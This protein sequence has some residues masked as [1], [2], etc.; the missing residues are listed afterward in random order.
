M[1]FFWV[2]IC[3]L[4]HVQYGNILF[5]LHKLCIIPL[6][7]LQLCNNNSKRYLSLFIFTYHSIFW[8]TPCATDYGWQEQ[9]REHRN[10]VLTRASVLP[11]MAHR[12][13]IPSSFTT[14]NNIL[15]TEFNLPSR[16]LCIHGGSFLLPQ[17]PAEFFIWVHSC[18]PGPQLNFCLTAYSHHPALNW[19]F[20]WYDGQVIQI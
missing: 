14:E 15:P 4:I 1:P 5:S 17:P 3:H 16:S 20:S 2:Y 8:N 6:S 12:W 9:D 10:S 11:S 19:I 7:S 13:Y 18:H